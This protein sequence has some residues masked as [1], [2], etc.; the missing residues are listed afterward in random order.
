MPKGGFDFILISNRVKN[1]I[2][3]DLEADFFL[4]GK[5]LWSGFN[6]KYIP[7]K[8]RKREIGKS[9]WTFSMKLK[10]FIDSLMSYSLFP[11]RAM[12]TIG[13]ILSISGF[14]YA[15]YVFIERLLSVDYVAGNAI[16]VI[17]ILILSEMCCK[18]TQNQW[19]GSTNLPDRPRESCQCC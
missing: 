2:L 19:Y 18:T 15:I 12:S 3:K 11:I 1:T 16:I 7:Y 17:L 10:W 6:I 4:Q 14:T 5:I 8:R 13:I 9:Q